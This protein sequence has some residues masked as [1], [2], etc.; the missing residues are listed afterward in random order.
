M[1]AQ[2][3]ML[4]ILMIMA[5]ALPVAIGTSSSLAVES[6]RN[7]CEAEDSALADANQ[8][9][10]RSR[11]DAFAYGE[12]LIARTTCVDAGIAYDTILSHRSIVT[13]ELGYA[14]EIP[15][16]DDVLQCPPGMSGTFTT[17]NRYMFWFAELDS[18][19][20]L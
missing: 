14:A 15:A 2:G 18:N 20:T 8:V 11:E 12:A 1:L 9:S 3:T 10:T 7:D 17:R 4:R 6:T 13:T 16:L 5:S 19:E